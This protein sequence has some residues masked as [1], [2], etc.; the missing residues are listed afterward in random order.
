MAHGSP[1]ARLELKPY[2][3]PRFHI[4]ESFALKT[5]TPVCRDDMT[6]T[7]WKES[8]LRWF[9]AA[10]LPSPPGRSALLQSQFAFGVVAVQFR[11]FLYRWGPV[12]ADIPSLLKA[13]EGMRLATGVEPLL[14]SI[15]RARSYQ[16]TSTTV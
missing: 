2:G 5:L 11:L 8:R 10:V 16:L 12:R 9:A 13:F 15:V 4:E 1:F 7:C 3:F 6:G 14:S